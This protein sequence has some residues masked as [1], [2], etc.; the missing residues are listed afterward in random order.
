[1]AGSRHGFVG[2]G[3]AQ[4]PV[5][6]RPISAEMHVALAFSNPEGIQR[7]GDTKT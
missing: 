7:C 3:H 1:M 5:G 4:E 6:F 2:N